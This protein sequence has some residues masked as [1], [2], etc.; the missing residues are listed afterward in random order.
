[1]NPTPIKNQAILRQIAT[2]QRGSLAT[3]VIVGGSSASAAPAV[4]VPPAVSA[5]ALMLGDTGSDNT[6][7]LAHARVS[8]VLLPS[9][10][11]PS[12]KLVLS[13]SFQVGLTGHDSIFHA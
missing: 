3:V 4:V 8:A 12:K 10:T 13:G 9:L 11:L 6:T 5:G 1:M 7:D 2:A